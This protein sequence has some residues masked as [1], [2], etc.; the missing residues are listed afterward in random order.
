MS[1]PSSPSA[2]VSG[3]AV[4][5]LHYAVALPEPHTHL[6]QVTLTIAQPSATQTLMLPVWIPGSYLVREFAR[7]VQGMTA[8]QSGRACP[9]TTLDKHRWQV[10][11]RAGVPLEVHYVVYAHDASVRAAWLDAER[12]FFNPAAVCV[13]AEGHAHLPHVL[14]LTEAPAGWELATAL[15]AQEVDARGLGCYAAPDYD[16]LADSPVELGRFW[17]GSFTAHGIPHRLVISQPPPSFDA[18]RLLADTR[19]ICEAEMRFWHGGTP[20]DA[21]AQPSPGMAPFDHYLFL[22]HTVQD[23]Y[24]GLEHSASTALIASRK[25]LPRPGVRPGDDYTTLL[26]LISHEYFH[27]WNVK[28][29]RPAD[30]LPYDYTQENYTSLLWFFEG[31]TSYYDDLLLLRAGCIDAATYLRQLDRTIEQVRATPGRHVQSVADAS[32]DAWIKYYRPDEHTP[33]ATVSYYTKGALVALCLDLTLREEGHA[34]LDDVMRLLWQRCCPQGHTQKGLTEADVADALETVG[35]RSFARELRQWV[36]GTAELPVEKLLSLHGVRILRS[37]ASLP[38]QWGLRCQEGPAGIQIQTVLRG[39]VAEAAGMAP[40]D[41]WL[42]VE[43]PDP[44]P[45]S[46]GAWRVATLADVE[47]LLPPP[48]PSGLREVTALVARDRRLLRLPLGLPATTVQQWKLGF[49]R[50]PGNRA[51]KH[52]PWA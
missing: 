23:G 19:R 14:A 42:G 43:L 29:L 2:Q 9:V 44:L 26:G 13:Q 35:G 22:L 8:R 6:L 32:R 16:T 40:G 31:I 21:D 48:G 47:A 45:G 10:S 17:S 36:H 28:R 38:R 46:H 24:G 3:P 1:A 27:A 33:N 25:T 11:C 51:H 4:A 15:P 12:C 50:P 7:H 41:E 49:S 5:A 18:D 34:S 37:A 20:P 52:W 39:G 30:L